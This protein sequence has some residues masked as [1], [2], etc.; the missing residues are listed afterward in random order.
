[1]LCLL[2]CRKLDIPSHAKPKKPVIS[3]V[4]I[5]LFSF[6]FFR[7]HGKIKDVSF[8]KILCTMQ[9]LEEICSLL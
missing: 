6:L 3:N 1:M 5:S 9:L 8:V 7:K 2:A 4:I